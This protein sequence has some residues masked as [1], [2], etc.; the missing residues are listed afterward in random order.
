MVKNRR[1][2]RGSMVCALS[3]AVGVSAVTRHCPS[4]L[5]DPHW[6]SREGAARAWRNQE[7]FPSGVPARS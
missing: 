4:F 5:P 6:S 1:T 3:F 2:T 7:A